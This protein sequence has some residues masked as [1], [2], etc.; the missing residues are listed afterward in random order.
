LV[1][2]LTKRFDIMSIAHGSMLIW[3][4]AVI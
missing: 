3:K 4:Y 1:L 2:Q